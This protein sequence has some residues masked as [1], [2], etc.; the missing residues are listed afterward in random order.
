MRRRLLLLPLRVLFAVMFLT[1]G[2]SG[3]VSGQAFAQPAAGEEEAAFVG[4]ASCADCHDEIYERFQA[5][6]KKAHTRVNVEKML[7]KLS[8]EEQNTCFQCHATGYGKK[9]GFISYAQTPALGDVGCETCHGPGSLHAETGDVDLIQRRPA[10]EQCL[11]C[12]NAERIQNFNF[13]PL[14]YSG[15]H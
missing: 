15:A 8:P 9:G 1:A 12:H 14:I 4:S 7:D 13:K 2:P 5:N 10:M 3:L 6:S 11:S